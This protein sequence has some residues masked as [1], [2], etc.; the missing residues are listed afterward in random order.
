MSGLAQAATV[1]ERALL[2]DLHGCTLAIDLS[3]VPDR[4]EVRRVIAL[5]WLLNPRTVASPPAGQPV[6]SIT[7][8]KQTQLPEPEGELLF[9][10]PSQHHGTHQCFRGRDGR[11]RMTVAGEAMAILDTN[12]DSALVLSDDVSDP[13]WAMG[14]LMLLLLDHALT[15]HNQCLC[16]AASVAT[17]DGTGCVILH[18]PSGTGKSTTAGALAS[19]GMPVLGDDTAALMQARGDQPVRAWGLPRGLRLHRRSAAMLPRFG[20]LA[21]DDA[22]DEEDEQMIARDRLVGAGLA[23]EADP[24]PVRAVIA[25]KRP[26]TETNRPSVTACD[27]FEALRD[28]MADNLS[29]NEHGFFS[30]H[31]RRLD[32][33]SQMV[34]RTAGFAVEIGGSPDAVAEAIRDCVSQR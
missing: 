23:I 8:R 13:P 7:V 30:G 20:A 16:H 29:A 18:A 11:L 6:C 19:L 2:Y 24:L 34:G 1:P 28:L 22:W 12:G 4:G 9:E 27:A 31:E 21:R 25:L 15:T 33:F 10:Y 3:A 32:I 5:E 14:E 17:P 26:D